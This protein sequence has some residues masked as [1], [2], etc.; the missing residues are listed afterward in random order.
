[1]P[2]LLAYAAC[3]MWTSACPLE[4]RLLS[5]LVSADKQTPHRTRRLAVVPLRSVG[6][7]RIPYVDVS[8]GPEGPPHALVHALALL[9]LFC[10]FLVAGAIVSTAAWMLIT[11]VM[12]QF[13]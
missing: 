10:R 3:V 7:L 12:D 13:V 4:I 1:M 11:A 2:S 9:A 5:L 8:T 6:M